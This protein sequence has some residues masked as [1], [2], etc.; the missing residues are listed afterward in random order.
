[1]FSCCACD[2]RPQLLRVAAARVNGRAWAPQVV[3][4]L[5]N[6]I[7]KYGEQMAPYAVQVK[8]TLNPSSR[9]AAYRLTTSPWTNNAHVVGYSSLNLTSALHRASVGRAAP[10]N[11]RRD[12]RWVMDRLASDMTG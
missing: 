1:M 6:L 2:H 7:E 3:S 10:T 11:S 4:T 12:T 8:P 9:P 5:D